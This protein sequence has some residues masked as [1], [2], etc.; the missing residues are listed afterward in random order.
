MPIPQKIRRLVL[1]LRQLTVPQKAAL[2]LLI[3]LAIRAAAFLGLFGLVA[4]LGL[5]WNR[6]PPL[7]AILLLLVLFCFFLTVFP[8]ILLRWVNPPGSAFMRQVQA[9][10]RRAGEDDTI[11]YHWVD[12]DDINPA[13]CLAVIALEDPDFPVHTG[14]AVRRMFEVWRENRNRKKL[15]GASSITQQL[16]KNLFLTPARTYSRKLVEAYITVLLEFVLSKRRILELYLNVVQFDKN[17]FGVGKAS[18]HFYGKPAAELT[19]EE[20]SLFVAVLPNPVY[21]RVD[22]P[23][24]GVRQRQAFVL[25][26]MEEYGLEYLKL[27]DSRRIEYLLSGLRTRRISP[28]SWPREI[29][30]Q[31]SP[32]FSS[33]GD[34]EITGVV[35]HTTVGEYRGAIHWLKYNPEQVS[36]HYVVREDGSEIT[37]MVEESQAAHHAGLVSNPSTPVYRGGNPNLYTIGIENADGGSPHCHIRDR[38]YRALADLVSDICRRNNIPV[39]RDH[40]CGHKELNDKTA[41]PG[42]LDVDKVV[43]LAKQGCVNT[44]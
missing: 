20:A 43:E 41:C 22:D 5:T 31:K 18:Q 23:S 2:K 26:R 39:D 29:K 36:A 10:L 37:Q 38:Q 7:A 33:R 32:Y 14:F 16:A 12:Y 8:L 21:Y 27:I 4:A 44:T 42:N 28:E 1:W 9:S 35:L 24:E 11:E 30:H 25:S 3:Y 17:V 6:L 13:M 15:Q 19:A 40:I 34:W